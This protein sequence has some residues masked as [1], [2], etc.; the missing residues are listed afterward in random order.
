MGSLGCL[1]TAC[2][3][4]IVDSFQRHGA[5]CPICWQPYT[6]YPRENVVIGGTLSIVYELRGAEQPTLASLGL[7]PGVFVRLF[8]TVEP[9]PD[10]HQGD[11]QHQLQEVQRVGST[12]E[13]DERNVGGGDGTVLN[14]ANQQAYGEGD[15]VSGRVA[16]VDVGGVATGRELSAVGPPNTAVGAPEDVDMA[17]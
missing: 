13:R 10:S 15:G 9:P 1:H 2:C 12:H 6:Q 7:D 5:K 11:V 16:V 8:Q 4:C 3:A 14:H 17:V